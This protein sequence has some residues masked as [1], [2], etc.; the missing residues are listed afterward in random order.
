ML[1]NAFLATTI[2]E[3]FQRNFIE[4]DRWLQLVNGLKV[5]LLVSMLAVVLGIVLG[6]LLALCR[7]SKV[8]PLSFIAGGYIDIIRGTPV[9]VQ[10]MIIYYLL[11]AR[12]G[13]DKTYIAAI[14][15][16]CN[17]AAYVSEIVR[18]GILSIEHGQTEA[19]RSLGLTEV[20]TMRYIVMP[21]AIKNILPALGNELITLIK[22]T[23]VSGY[24]GL[25]DLTRAGEQIRSR[26]FD[27]FLTLMVV[28]AVYYV[29]V[30]VLSF[31]L[32]KLERSLRASDLR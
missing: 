5:T 17:S 24:I 31:L 28:A 23:S 16:G 2:S 7:L 22:E 9:V 29:L 3:Q 14:A 10:L 11:L 26:T 21:Q 27:A 13:M 25:A 4:A 20:M 15:F 1:T 18:A 8:K 6:I 19:G 32:Q 12:T 30:K